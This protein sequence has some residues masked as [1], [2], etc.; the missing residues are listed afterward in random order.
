[1]WSGQGQLHQSIP[2]PII[3]RMGCPAK[4][5]LGETL[6]YS[7]N[8]RVSTAPCACIQCTYSDRMLGRSKAELTSYMYRL[9]RDRGGRRH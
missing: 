2:Y 7:Q 6:V 4:Y 8:R 3:N 1:M 5:I 9:E